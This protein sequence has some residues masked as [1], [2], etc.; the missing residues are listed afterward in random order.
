MDATTVHTIARSLPKEEYARLFELL[1][2]DIHQLEQK[3]KLRKKKVQLISDI[4]ARN[5]LLKSVFKIQLTS[6]QSQL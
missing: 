1:K 4:E 3:K 2:K 5:Y 6:Q